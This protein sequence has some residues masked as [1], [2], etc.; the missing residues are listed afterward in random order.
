MQ[1]IKIFKSEI[2]QFSQNKANFPPYFLLTFSSG[3]IPPPQIPPFLRR[4]TKCNQDFKKALARR[5]EIVEKAKVDFDGD[6]KILPGFP[7]QAHVY[8]QD[9]K[10]KQWNQRGTIVVNKNN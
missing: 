5:E 7:I 2:A 1:K 6:P 9:F 10:T 8:S 3:G 4:N